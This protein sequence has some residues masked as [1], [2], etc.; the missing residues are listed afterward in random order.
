LPVLFLALSAGSS[1]TSAQTQ[2]RSRT[3]F[4]WLAG[5]TL[6]CSPTSTCLRSGTS[7]SCVL[8][9]WSTQWHADAQ[10]SSWRCGRG[11]SQN[12]I[13]QFA[14]STA[15][16]S[17]G[18]PSPGSYRPPRHS[19][20]FILRASAMGQSC[21]P[22]GHA[23]AR[24]DAAPGLRCR[25]LNCGPLEPGEGLGYVR[26]TPVVL[27]PRRGGFVGTF[28]MNFKR[29]LPVMAASVLNVGSSAMGSSPPRWGRR[30]RAALAVAT[31]ERPR[32]RVLIGG[33]LVLAQRAGSGARSPIR[34]PWGG[35]HRASCHCHLGQRTR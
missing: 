30:A 23:R 10:S 24:L 27:G 21:R 18:R 22:A 14:V 15:R 29:V 16:A 6:A 31:L 28:G 8:L 7:R 20:C 25:E 2:D 13:P 9:D 26:S 19:V 17:L 1:L 12:A 32:F 5:V 34:S 4:T 35:L 11:E 33:G 3:R